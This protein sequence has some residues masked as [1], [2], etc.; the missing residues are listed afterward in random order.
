MTSKKLRILKLFV[1]AASLSTL[2]LV[3]VSSWYVLHNNDY[4]ISSIGVV[5]FGRAFVAVI[6]WLLHT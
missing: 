4:D 2:G 1:K 3:G 5:R 6:N